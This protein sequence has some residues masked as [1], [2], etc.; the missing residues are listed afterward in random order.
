MKKIEKN[1]NYQAFSALFKATQT[2]ALN[3]RTDFSAMYARLPL[4]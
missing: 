3:Y 1:L 2:L 4:H